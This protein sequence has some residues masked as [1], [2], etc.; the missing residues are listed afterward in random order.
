MTE[1]RKHAFVT[2]EKKIYK[3]ARVN[4]RIFP[5]MMEK[6]IHVDSVTKDLE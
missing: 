4:H 6:E 2:L 5:T 1:E 3:T